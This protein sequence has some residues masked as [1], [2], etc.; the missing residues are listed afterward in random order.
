MDIG[1]LAFLL[2]LSLVG[3]KIK[4]FLPIMVFSLLPQK[5]ARRLFLRLR[6]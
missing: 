3:G 4:D 6:R 1:L 5:F 2:R